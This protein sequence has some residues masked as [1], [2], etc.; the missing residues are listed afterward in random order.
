MP[1][2][3]VRLSIDE[4]SGVDHPAHLVEGWAVMKSVDPTDVTAVLDELRPEEVTVEPTVDETAVAKDAEIEAVEPEAA[5]A[6]EETFTTPVSKEETMPETETVDVATPEVVIVPAAADLA[7]VIKA[8]P[9]SIRKILDDSQAQAAE[10]LAIAKA[11]QAELASERDNRADEAAVMKA[12]KWSSL[13][14]DPTIVGPALR[15]LTDVDP[16]LAGEV[17]KALDAANA[18]AETHAV[19]EEIGSDATPSVAN[20][21]YSQIENLAKAAVQAGTSPSFESALLSV[22]QA[23]PDLYTQYISERSR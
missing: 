11:A 16:T 6:D 20:D 1:R 2:K 4:T 10:S 19:F 13:T 17:F 18:V 21:A 5:V 9:E 12:A 14:L 7:D 22:A 3:L 8:M 15:R 23:N